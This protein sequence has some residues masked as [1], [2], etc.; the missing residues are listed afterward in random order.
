MKAQSNLHTM[1]WLFLESIRAS[2]FQ[3]DRLSGTTISFGTTSILVPYSLQVTTVAAGTQGFLIILFFFF[4]WFT[5]FF[6][7]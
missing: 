5:F 6:F 3:K 4:F 7:N 1:C 2:V